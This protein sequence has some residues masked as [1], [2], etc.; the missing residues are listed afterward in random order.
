MHV[1]A[2]GEAKFWIE[3]ADE[4]HANYGPEGAAT[5]G[6]SEVGEEHMDFRYPLVIH[7]VEK[8]PI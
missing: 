7:Q 1:H 8:T 2:E 3:P 4:L 5:R 6:G